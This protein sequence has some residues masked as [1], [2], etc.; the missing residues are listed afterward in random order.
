MEVA[1]SIAG[2]VALADLVFRYSI[3]YVKDFAGARKDVKD[4]SREIKNLSL[5]LHN[6]SL[7]AFELEEAQPS[8]GIQPSSN[9]KPLHLHDCQ[10][11]LNRL[12]KG[13]GGAQS[14]LDSTSF[15]KRFRGRLKWPFS[16]KDTKEILQEVER[17]KQTM[18]LAL[19]ADSLSNLRLL[20]SRLSITNSGVDKLQETVDKILDIETKIRLDTKRENV[21]EFF[22]KVNPHSEFDTNRGL[23]HPLT[24]LWLTE[25]SEFEEWYTTPGSKIWCSG[26]PGAGKSVLAAAIIDEC[27]QRNATN[28]RTALAYFF[29]TYRDEKAQE[30]TSILASLCSQL[31]RQDENAFQTLE[32]YHDELTSERQLQAGPSAKRLIKVLRSMCSSFNRVY[33]IVDGLDECGEQVEESLESLVALL[34]SPDDETLNLALLSRDE[35]PIR[36]IMGDDFRNIEIEAHTEDIQLYVASELEQR[37]ASRKLRLRDLSLKDQIMMR[38]VDGAKGMFRWV[39]CQLDHICEFRTDGARRKAL[40]KLPPTLFATYERILTRIDDSHEQDRQLLQR[41]LLLIGSP[42]NA[43][44]TL[45]QIC[46]AI[47]LQDDGEELPDEDIVSEEELLRLCSSL[48]RKR[49]MWWSEEARDGVGLEFSHFS[50]Q[51]YLQHEC[52]KHATLSAYGI[53]GQK[54]C[55][56]LASLCLGHL[57]PKN[58]ERL[59]ETVGAA[60]E[61]TVG[62]NS[63]RP[64]YRHAATC[65]PLYIHDL[66]ASEGDYCLERIYDLFQI[67]KTPSFCSWAMEIAGHSMLMRPWQLPRNWFLTWPFT[68]MPE[69][70]HVCGPELTPLHMAAAL[71]MPDLCRYL[72]GRGASADVEGMFGTPL[73]CAISGLWVFAF[74]GSYH[75]DMIS[76][77]FSVVDQPLGRLQA[78]R[79]LLEAG[80][81]PQLR[82][83]TRQEK[84]FSSLSLVPLSPSFGHNFEIA[85]ELIEA[86]VAV[87]EEE[88]AHFRQRYNAIDQKAYS[89]FNGQC[90]GEQAVAS[91]LGALGPPETDTNTTPRSLLYIETLNWA[92]RMKTET[93]GQLST[94]QDGVSDDDLVELISDWIKK[95]DVPKLCQFLTSSRSE[96]AKSARFDADYFGQGW[97]SL[98][99]AVRHSSLGALNELLEHGLDPNMVDLDGKTASHLCA[100]QHSHET[101]RALLQHGASTLLFDKTQRTV[102]HYAAERE[103]IGVLGLLVELDDRQD[104]LQMVSSSD[105]TPICSALNNRRQDA[106]LFLLKYCKSRKFWKSGRSIFRAAASLGSSKLARHLVDVQVARDGMDDFTG[107]PLHYLTPRATVECIRPLKGLFP[108]DQR[109]KDDRMTP[110]ETLLSRAA[111]RGV[112]LDHKVLKAMLP[113]AAIL[114]PKEASNLWSFVISKWAKAVKENQ[115]GQLNW[116][117]G[118][119]FSL[120][121]LEIMAKYEQESKESALVPFVSAVVCDAVRLREAVSKL[122]EEQGLYREWYTL[123]EVMRHIVNET[124]HWDSTVDE[125]S[126]IRLLSLAMLHGDDEM[127][128]L[129]VEK[130]VDLHSTVDGLSPFDF[131]CFPNV[132][133]SEKSFGLLLK[134][135]TPLRVTRGNESF[136]GRGPLHFCAGWGELGQSCSWKLEK[137]LQTGVGP[138]WPLSAEYGPPLTYHIRRGAIRT[139]EMLL[140][141]GADPWARGSYP[142][143]APLE[144]VSHGH[145]SI[146]AKIAATDNQ[147]PRWDRTWVKPLDDGQYAGGNALHLAARHGNTE[148]LEFYLNQELLSDLE[149]RDDGL[150]TPMHYAAWFDHSSTVRSLEARGGNIN[151]RECNGYTPLHYAICNKYLEVARTL[152]DLGAKHQAYT[153]DCVGLALAY[154][155][156]D[157]AMI[158]LVQNSLHGCRETA[159]SITSPRNLRFLGNAMAN[160]IKNGDVSLCERIHALGCPIDVE[161]KGATPLAVA[162]C[163]QDD[164]KIAQWLLN[165]GATV[166]AVF[167]EPYQEKYSTALE[168]AA[169]HPAMNSLLPQ[170][171]EKYLKEGGSFLDMDQSPL[172]FSIEHENLEG[173]KILL[174]WLRDTYESPEAKFLLQRETLSALV[175]QHHA[176]HP[177]QTALHLAAS[178]NNM[179]ACV[180]LLESRA[181]IEETNADGETPLHVAARCGSLQAAKCL[182]DWGARSDPLDAWVETPLMSAFQGSHWE[183]VDLLTP[184]CQHLTG[185]NYRGENLLHFMTK[186]EPDPARKGLSLDIFSRCFDQGAS[187]YLGDDEGISPMHRMLASQSA[188]SLRSLLSR[189]YL[190]LRPQEMVQWPPGCFA[191]EV[192]NLSAISRNLHLVRPFLSRHEL[193]QLSGVTK[194]GSHSLLCGAA[195]GGLVEAIQNFV[196]LGADMMNHQCNHHGT[197]VAAAVS[198][199]QIEAVKCLV[200]NGATVPYDLC[201]P[202]DSEVNVGN[203]DFVIREWLFVGRYL[204]RRGISDGT[205]EASDKIESWAGIRTVKVALKWGWKRR[206]EESTQKY[207][208][209]RQRILKD[210][211]GKVVRCVEGADDSDDAGGDAMDWSC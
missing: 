27:L 182:L 52:L 11:L 41:T 60:I 45:Q 115:S 162:I 82:F 36:E 168:A 143:D 152:I 83:M 190:F 94:H 26:I 70:L 19:A 138:N 210:L 153:A 28:P 2:L 108:L 4:I 46:E 91:L 111:E 123:A 16:S 154:V 22:T 87:E 201:Q 96:L 110:L 102:W 200:R 140:E 208:R 165:S 185:T 75:R 44:L 176:N 84:S 68:D 61:P 48:V 29:C 129:L 1:A 209:K 171:L 139:A 7:V 156:G 205:A 149:C 159:T 175:S 173:L 63:R 97:T 101:L 198:S 164:P 104:A 120:V 38:L 56:L 64:F 125:P 163:E 172:H 174:G 30:P 116:L 13:L 211:R 57:T 122:P 81:K 50:V 170:L 65:W 95:D 203:P 194:S 54:A 124:G 141:A 130:G 155:E 202:R 66:P 186:H 10:R 105:E 148:C 62:R 18:E 106:V 191:F 158:D 103:S 33:I 192:D 100:F 24:G 169:A 195:C 49:R 142:F 21:L 39:A 160:A 178:E 166:S 20:L 167:P 12:E 107:N 43:E 147:P 112:E 88:L 71:G 127:V 78:V 204:E 23:R 196:A 80:A 180:A 15:F 32:K 128:S 51:E 42:H 177:Q 207:A 113:G 93:F 59:P 85:V 181:N 199:R 25:S 179:D 92:A 134:H 74:D 67:P 117:K 73:H 114:D 72:L 53:S 189:D 157:S 86:G 69:P 76:P 188:G 37:I 99:L 193:C 183:L 5:V 146:L 35:V 79:V 89:E 34:P 184:H 132:S 55:H 150:K 135:T 126:V 90:G 109:R 131:A 145:L 187:L 98:H 31:A 144:A 118:V 119:V 161:V 121:Q 40:D 197:P 133:I 17:H 206:R 3:K 77:M 9:F 137:I 136:S 47:S 8:D 6:L 151:A 58:H 14:N